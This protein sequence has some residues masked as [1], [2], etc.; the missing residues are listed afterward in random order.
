MNR[1]K[2]WIARINCLLLEI[3]QTFLLDLCVFCDH[4]VDE[5]IKNGILVLHRHHSGVN[6]SAHCC[7]QSNSSYTITSR[8]LFCNVF[9][10]SLRCVNCKLC[11]PLSI[12]ST[13]YVNVCPEFNKILLFQLYVQRYDFVEEFSRIFAVGPIFRMNLTVWSSW[14]RYLGSKTIACLQCA[15]FCCLNVNKS[16]F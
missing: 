2:I 11:K 14:Q 10:I 4:R 9:R 16:C 8:C 1:M 12:R 15:V 13:W 3:L 5:W 7:C 6:W